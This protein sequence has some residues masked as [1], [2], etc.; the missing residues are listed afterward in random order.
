MNVTLIEGVIVKRPSSINK[1]PYVADVKIGE[2][3][4]LAHCPAL[5][6]GHIIK[7]GTKVLM[8]KIELKD[9]DD[10]KNERKCK[11]S[12]QCAYD[13]EFNIYTGSY[14][15]NANKIFELALKAENIDIVKD[16]GELSTIKKIKSEHVY[17]YKDY[18]SR[19]DF[20]IEYEC[21]SRKNALIEIKSVPIRINDSGIFPVGGNIKKTG[22]ISER[23]NKHLCELAEIAKS[24][25]FDCFVVFILL[26]N[27][28]NKVTPNCKD[29]LFC[30]AIEKAMQAGVNFKVYTS[31][32]GLKIDSKGIFNYNLNV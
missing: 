20:Y 27:D 10:E 28:V 22:T 7:S 18:K 32:S 31:D 5:G 29:K 3:N 12:I 8:K 9:A 6:L 26:R 2:Y 15:T 14:P 1:S 13:E 19:F 17:N 11:Y 16:F 24:G 21:K 4:Y 30:D 25:E 23:A